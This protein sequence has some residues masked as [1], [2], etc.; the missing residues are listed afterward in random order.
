MVFLAKQF[1]MSNIYVY[2]ALYHPSVTKKMRKQ[3][4]IFKQVEIY[5][6]TSAFLSLSV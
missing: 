6:G 3:G 1:L 5:S 4:N 2:N